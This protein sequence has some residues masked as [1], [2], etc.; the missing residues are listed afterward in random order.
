MWGPETVQVTTTPDAAIGLPGLSFL[1]IAVFVASVVFMAWRKL[2]GRS[3]VRRSTSGAAM[4]NALMDL[5]SA[6]MPHHANAAVVCKLEEEEEQDTAGEGPTPW[7]AP[8]PLPDT[9]YRQRQDGEW[10][11]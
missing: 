4:G 7:T 6:F 11:N 2:K 8:V 5:N 9:P 1:A 3:G 10:L